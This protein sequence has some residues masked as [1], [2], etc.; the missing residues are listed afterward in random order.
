MTRYR[1][2]AFDDDAQEVSLFDLEETDQLAKIAA[3]A[4][5]EDRAAVRT[6]KG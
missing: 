6:L 3:Q 1:Q 5:E 4:S 2:R